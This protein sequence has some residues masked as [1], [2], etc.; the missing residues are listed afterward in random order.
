[1]WRDEMK[2]EMHGPGA[3]I[4]LEPV[5]RSCREHVGIDR[6]FLRFFRPQF[7]ELVIS[8]IGGEGTR[9]VGCRGDAG[10]AVTRPLEML[11]E[12]GGFVG[13]HQIFGDH[14]V[15]DER[16]ARDHGWHRLARVGHQRERIGE[17]Q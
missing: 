17:D 7:N 4:P 6:F 12:G 15:V 11:G 2:L 16:E 14:L 8:L 10:G 13:Q 1:M 5:D 9:I 3:L